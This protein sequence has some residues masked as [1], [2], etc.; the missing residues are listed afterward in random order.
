M[1]SMEEGTNNGGVLA[2]D[3]GLGKTISA[4]ALLLSRPSMDP[5]CKVCSHSRSYLYY[6]LF[7][8]TR[9]RL[10]WL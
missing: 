8:L 10:L 5:A 1:K 4:L 3:M 6:F 7:Y 9:G 2:D